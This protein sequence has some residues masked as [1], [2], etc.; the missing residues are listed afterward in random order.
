LAG[1]LLIHRVFLSLY[2]NPAGMVKPRTSWSSDK[3]AGGLCNTYKH[4]L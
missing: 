3:T 1:F 2:G 4:H